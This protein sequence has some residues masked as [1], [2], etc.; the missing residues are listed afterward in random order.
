MHGDD[1]SQEQLPSD[2]SLEAAERHLDRL[3]HWIFA[4][5]VKIALFFGVASGMLWFLAA[6]APKA[7]YSSWTILVSL[8]AVGP[9]MASLLFLFLAAT[10]R[11][12]PAAPSV[13]YF[14][15]A[16]NIEREEFVASFSRQNVT[17][18]LHDLLGQCHEN[19]RILNRRYTML[20]RAILG[21][22]IAMIPWAFASIFFTLIDV[23]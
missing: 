13:L 21:I 17:E 1:T 22:L 5:D 3:A 14:G 8:A 18:R 15:S 16:S 2:Y 6:R 19:S 9:L 7:D 10:P 11:L 20:Q 4:T 12:K 23:P